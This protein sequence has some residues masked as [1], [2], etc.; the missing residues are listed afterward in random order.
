VLLY[1]PFESLAETTD[2]DVV[3]ASDLLKLSADH[4][5][6]FGLEYR[7]TQGTSS[8]QSIF[9]GTV[10]Y[11]VVAASTMWNWD[12]LPTLSLTNAVRID[13][14]MLNRSGTTVFGPYLLNG[15]TLADYGRSFQSFSFNSGLVYKVSDSDTVRL[16]AARGLQSPSLVD[17][18]YVVVGNPD[19]NPTVVGNY[20][21]AYDKDVVALQTTMRASVFYQTQDDIIGNIY[22]DN[23]VLTPLGFR[24][25][26]DNIGSSHETG[27]ELGF[28]GHSE[29]G[30]RWDGSYSFATLTDHLDIIQSVPR[31]SNIDYQHGTPEHTVKLGGGYSVGSW[32]F[33]AHAR[34]Q[35]SWTTYKQISQQLNLL[36]PPSVGA[37]QVPNYLSVNARVGYKITERLTVSGTAEQFNQARIATS[38]GLPNERRF[39]IKLTQQF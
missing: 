24:N 15:S 37:F 19:L 32:E 2:T 14:V 23:P 27:I 1:L 36:L 25:L 5:V 18:G 35:S 16:M 34:W 12:I 6:R 8:A 33:D 26:V 10:G 21:L 7:N 31:T 9:G 22:G 20:E 3:Q 29:S 4:T 13:D 39:L 17:F 11:Q 38:N 28:K 30:W